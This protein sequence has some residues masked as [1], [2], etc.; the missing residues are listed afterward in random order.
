M[1]KELKELRSALQI[2]KDFCVNH[3][4]SSGKEDGCE[5]C[6]L[7]GEIGHCLLYGPEGTITKVDD[8][9]IYPEMDNKI[10][11]IC[12]GNEWLF[13]MVYDKELTEEHLINFAVYMVQKVVN[14]T[15]TEMVEDQY[16]RLA[17]MLNDM[18]GRS[19]EVNDNLIRVESFI[20][21]IDSIVKE[22][23]TSISYTLWRKW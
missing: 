9:V 4:H 3:N 8:V 19:C 18:R 11:S 22:H 2:V 20:K 16:E 6:P 14:H 13:K 23:L 1:N 7:M 5:K 12:G 17:V 15:I 21:D 10:I